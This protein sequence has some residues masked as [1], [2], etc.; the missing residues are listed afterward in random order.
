[1]IVS[2]SNCF[3]NNEFKINESYKYK[4]DFDIDNGDTYNLS[5]F[6]KTSLLPPRRND[7]KHMP[8]IKKSMF[9]LLT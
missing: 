2:S 1:M 4:C 5:K 7:V 8:T 3:N 9:P 6:N